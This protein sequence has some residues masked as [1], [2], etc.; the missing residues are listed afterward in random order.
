MIHPNPEVTA[1]CLQKMIDD[2]W[3][4]GANCVGEHVV[5][6]KVIDTCQGARHKKAVTA[7]RQIC[8]MCIVQ[9]SCLKFGIRYTDPVNPT[10]QFTE[11]QIPAEEGNELPG[12]S[13]MYGGYTIQK[14]RQ[15]WRQKEL[16]RARVN[17]AYGARMSFEYI[18]QSTRASDTQ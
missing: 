9:D 1:E 15:M 3:R 16:H 8:E 4:S 10:L 11:N 7:A 17:A 2:D 6:D 5:F 12:I 13:G 14:L 18:I